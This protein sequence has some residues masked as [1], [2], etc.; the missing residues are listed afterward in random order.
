V[1]RFLLDNLGEDFGITEQE[2]FL[3]KSC[4][5]LHVTIIITTTTY[6]TGNLDGATTIGGKKDLITSIDLERDVLTF[7]VES[8]LTNSNNDTFVQSFLSLLGNENTSGSFLKRIRLDTPL[9]SHAHTHTHTHT[10]THMY[11]YNLLVE[12]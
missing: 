5:W 3:F 6:L 8:T 11:M 4:Q 9:L 2:V 7:L 1:Y 12:A 10:H